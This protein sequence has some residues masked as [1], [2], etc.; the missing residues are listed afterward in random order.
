MALAQDKRL[1]SSLGPALSSVWY[2][3]FLA[4]V[5]AGDFTAANKSLEAAERASKEFI[6]QLAMDDPRRLIFAA[7][8]LTARSRMQLIEHKPLAAM[9]GASTE[10]SRLDR[11]KIPAKDVR[12][13]TVMNNALGGELRIASMAAIQLGRYAQA[14]A[15]ARR[16]LALPPDPDPDEAPQIEPSSARAVL[17]QAVA[18]QGRGAEALAI[19]E[20]ALRYYRDEQRA[21]ANDTSMRRDFASAL[22]ASALAYSADPDGRAKR[23]AALAEATRLIAGATAEARQLASMR[24]LVIWIAAARAS[25]PD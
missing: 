16:R 20:P 6:A 4:E 8:G 13:A 14:E 24:D 22:Y 11:I 15:W 18:L 3:L 23:D 1:P 2:R 7:T 5:Q 21:G 10:I 19:L 17:A 9:N 12:L 25:K